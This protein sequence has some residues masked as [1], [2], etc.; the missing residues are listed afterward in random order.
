MLL[1][2]S[3]QTANTVDSK[4]ESLVCLHALRFVRQNWLRVLL[5]S[6]LVIV[7]C[8]WHKRIEA[9]D[10]GS[11]TYNAWLAQL[12]ESGQAPGLYIAP[13]STNILVDLLLVRLGSVLGLAAAEKIVVAWCVLVFFWGAFALIAAASR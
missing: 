4:T 8:F 6:A 1:K 2:L 5:I 12:V 3:H 10:L 7:P 11:H 9:G 13:Q